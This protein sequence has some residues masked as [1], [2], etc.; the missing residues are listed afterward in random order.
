MRSLKLAYSNY[1]FVSATG[2]LRIMNNAHWFSDVVVGAGIGIL[3]TKIV[4]MFNPLIKWNPFLKKK[5]LS[6]CRR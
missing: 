2:A 5:K 1:V 6:Y 3:V 4:Y